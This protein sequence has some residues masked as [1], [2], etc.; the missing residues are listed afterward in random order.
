MKKITI[1]LLFLFLIITAC[2]TKKETPLSTC[3]IEVH[4]SGVGTGEIS[5]AP[6]Q[7]VQSMEEY[8][9]FTIKD[10]L[11]NNVSIIEI[12]T[13]QALRRV[14]LR[15]NNKT[16]STQLFTGVGTYK[17]IIENDSLIVEGTPKHNEFLKI[18]NALGI[19]KM[20]RLKYKK[21]PTEAETNFI[22]N[23]AN[24]LIETIK[25]HPENVAL[26]QT[27]YAQFWSAD[28]TTLDKVIN[29]FDVSLL[30]NYF[31]EPLV[32]RRKNLDLVKVGQPAP[33]FTL[34]SIENKD[35]S[36]SDYK[37]KHLLIDFWAYWCGPCIKG[38]PELKEIRKS[39]SEE[40]L[41]I[42]SISTDKN[43][44]KWVEA[45]KQHKLPWPQV[46]DDANLPVDVGSKYA[47]V[48]IPHLIL[49]SP[50]G[51]IIYKHQYTDN[52]TDELAK[53]LN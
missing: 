35:I 4:T 32:E 11:K 51:K 16:Y 10:S 13:T 50:E 43:Y 27:A 45:V 47:V 6:Y 44:D 3:K 49:V 48:A 20:E 8:N 41:A 15:H 21:D 46:I 22:N 34:K 14:T 42:L 12:D 31:L 28:A 37:G 40:K 2:N 52:L 29:S 24:K 5:I 7:R 30:N 33:N 9:K 17:L 26:A 18:S 53:I 1:K 38:F 39:Y 36:L 23:Y 25:K 19:A